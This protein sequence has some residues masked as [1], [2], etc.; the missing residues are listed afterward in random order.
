MMLPCLPRG[1]SRLRHYVGASILISTTLFALFS[2]YN[3]DVTI[4]KPRDGN[5]NGG[6]NY[7]VRNGG[8][9]LLAVDTTED[10]PASTDNADAV[11][12]SIS[13]NIKSRKRIAL[14]RPFGPRDGDALLHSFDLWD[15]RW[16][17][18]TE[19]A[20]Y[21]VDLVI[22]YSRRLND[23][24]EYSE[25]ASQTVEAIRS[26]FFELNGETEGVERKLGWA[27]CFSALGVIEAEI[28]VS[29]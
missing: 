24:D 2:L 13:T 12:S 16:P 23:E 3:E 21:D 9:T 18:S 25:I 11:S 26:K 1:R 4:G 14:L 5:P 29:F 22:S 28:D 20:L 17:C 10:A 6:F 19:S 7:Y 15:T 8:R 27:S